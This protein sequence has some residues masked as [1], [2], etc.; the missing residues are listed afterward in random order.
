MSKELE[1]LKR[2]AVGIAAEKKKTPKQT[3]R[4]L[5]LDERFRQLKTRIVSLE[6][7]EE[8]RR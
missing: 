3:P 5:E 6:R 2:Q 4:Y 8:K 1:D 7:E